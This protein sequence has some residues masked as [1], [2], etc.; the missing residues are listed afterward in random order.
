MDVRLVPWS[1]SHFALLE[2]INTPLMRRH[3]GGPETAGQLL[4][5]H[6]RYLELP[7]L[8]GV[9]F[10]VLAGGEPA[11]SIA[12]HRRNWQGEE[13]YETGWN[14]LPEFQGR[15]L[16]VAAGRLMLAALRGVVAADPAAPGSLHAFPA[17]DNAPSNALCARL[18]FT[19]AGPCAFEYPRGSGRFLRSNDWRLALR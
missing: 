19:D 1:E 18:G 16:A 17:V 3:V 2:R 8:G 7:S 11:G 10:A 13:V 5:R 14:V 15:G 4:D 12:Y 9:M 6:R